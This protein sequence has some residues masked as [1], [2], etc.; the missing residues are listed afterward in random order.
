LQRERGRRVAYVS[1]AW[2]RER[3]QVKGCERNKTSTSS[4]VRTTQHN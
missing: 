3:E 2:A 4:M 1:V